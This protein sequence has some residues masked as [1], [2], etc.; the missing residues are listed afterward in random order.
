MNSLADTEKRN[1]T[2]RKHKI[3]LPNAQ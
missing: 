3:Y 2:N 1:S